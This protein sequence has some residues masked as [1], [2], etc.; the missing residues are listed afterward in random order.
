MYAE[1]LREAAPCW[2]P[3]AGTGSGCGAGG[4]VGW[5]WMRPSI[6]PHLQNSSSS[7]VGGEL[8]QGRKCLPGD[9]S[10]AE[11]WRGESWGHPPPGRSCPGHQ[12]VPSPSFL[13]RFPVWFSKATIWYKTESRTHLLI[14][15]HSH[16]TVM[17]CSQRRRFEETPR[18]GRMCIPLLAPSTSW[19]P[20]G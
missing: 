4:R 3:S 10:L 16:Q 8:S 5:Q 19:G 15:L 14:P 17:T 6:S 12:K 11:S 9:M 2:C 1:I 7:S 18:G 20:L 13:L